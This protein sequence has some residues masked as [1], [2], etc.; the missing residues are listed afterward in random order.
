VSNQTWVYQNGAVG[1]IGSEGPWALDG[2]A[3]VLLSDQENS[4]LWGTIPKSV[5]AG[6]CCAVDQ[7]HK[8]GAVI[9]FGGVRTTLEGKND[10][11]LALHLERGHWLDYTG[12]AVMDSCESSQM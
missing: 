1:W 11:Q 9:R 12:A 7:S 3:F 6:A 2:S 4:T 5:L 8:S 10:F